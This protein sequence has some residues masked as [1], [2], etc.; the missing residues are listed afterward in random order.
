MWNMLPIPPPFAIQQWIMKQSKVG[1]LGSNNSILTLLFESAI[2]KN[3]YR[4]S[5]AVFT[6]YATENGS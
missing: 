6:V 5:K 4:L 3:D 2:Q 1:L